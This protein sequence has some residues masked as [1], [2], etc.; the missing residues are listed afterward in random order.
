MGAYHLI[1]HNPF[2]PYAKGAHVSDPAE[3]SRILE[4]ALHVNVHRIVPPG[5]N[6]AAAAAAR[7]EPT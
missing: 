1:V 3:V 5:Q 4:S 7:E 2:G 6:V